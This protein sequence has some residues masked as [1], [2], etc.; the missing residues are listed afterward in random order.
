MEMNHREPQAGHSDEFAGAPDGQAVWE[1]ELPWQLPHP[2]QAGEESPLHATPEARAAAEVPPTNPDAT[3]VRPVAQG[4]L[5]DATAVPPVAHGPVSDTSTH[6]PT[7][8]P[9]GAEGESTGRRT[10]RPATSPQPTGGGGRRR[11]S[12]GAGGRRPGSRG[13]LAKPILAGAGLLSALLLLAPHLFGDD[14]PLQT[15]KAG[16]EDREPETDTAPDPGHPDAAK[17]SPGPAASATQRGKDSAGGGHDAIVEVA[18]TV[19]TESA[20]PATGPTAVPS[21]TRSATPTKAAPAPAATTEQWTTTVVNGTRVLDPGQ[22]WS[23]NRIGLNFQGD[24][25]LVLYDTKGTPL[26]W[27]GTVGQG[28]V[29]A[30]F[31][32]DGNLA[33]YSQDSRTVWSSHTEGHDGARLVL[34]ADGNMVIEQGGTVL[35][36]TGTAM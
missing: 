10:S 1:G 30:V 3:A 18:A 31:Q 24:G 13:H 6:A 26:W 21:A 12:A 33:V 25:N 7:G 14:A 9:S 8:T 5:S 23:T 4:P 11:R 32:A 20:K 22:L 17:T 16:A 28:G 34:R 2:D 36:S 29:R 35:W 15:V 27:S 19:P